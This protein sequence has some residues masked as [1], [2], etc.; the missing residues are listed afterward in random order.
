MMLESFA[1][2]IIIRLGFPYQQTHAL[3]VRLQESS[4]HIWP[5]SSICGKLGLSSNSRCYSIGFHNAFL[6]P[7][8]NSCR[9]YLQ[10][11]LF[12]EFEIYKNPSL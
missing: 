2:L 11:S 12:L 7:Q 5:C 8:S 4:G 1:L 3:M 9:K 10:L 6:E